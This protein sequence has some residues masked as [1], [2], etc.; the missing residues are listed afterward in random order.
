MVDGAAVIE[1]NLDTR[2]QANTSIAIRVAGIV[3]Y[4]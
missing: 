4:S 2:E 1:T 3:L